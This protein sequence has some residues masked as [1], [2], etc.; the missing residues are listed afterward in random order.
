MIRYAVINDADHL[1]D[2]F[3]DCIPE[4]LDRQ[5]GPNQF[6]IRINIEGWIEDAT[7]VYDATTNSIIPRNT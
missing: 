4:D 3:G 2:K 6:A 5:A 1:I 7:H